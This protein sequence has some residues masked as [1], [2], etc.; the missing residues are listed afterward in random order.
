MSIDTMG[1]GALDYLPCRYGSSKLVFRGPRR[2]LG[3]PF[4]AFVGSSETY[5]KFIK[6]P[7]PALV[8]QQL[9]RACVNFGLLNAGVDAFV[10]DPFVRN[11]A[12]QADVTVVQIM[13]AQNMTNRFY[14]VHPRRNDRFDAKD[15]RNY[16]RMTK[17]YG[18]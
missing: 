18:G 17:I 6:E 16:S 2:E 9:G 15:T 4:V 8:E 12:A 14:A 11:T 5:G 13:G 10:H 3:Q 1:P 7:F